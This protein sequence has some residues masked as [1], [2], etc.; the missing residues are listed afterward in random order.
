LGVEANPHIIDVARANLDAN[1]LEAISL[2]HG[3]AGVSEE[4]DFYVDADDE[5]SGIYA[6]DCFGRQHRDTDR[7]RVAPV[8][9]ADDWRQLFGHAPCDLL[10]IDIEGAEG[11]FLEL[12]GDFVRTVKYIAVEYHDTPTTSR[13]AIESLLS[14]LGFDVVAH[15]ANTKTIG[16]LFA[17]SRMLRK[18]KS[19]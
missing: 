6:V 15:E 12:E 3:A 4:V 19:A 14:K 9:V 8:A 18:S 17:E 16:V 7:I 10:K 13:T 2:R 1:H 11:L 5:L